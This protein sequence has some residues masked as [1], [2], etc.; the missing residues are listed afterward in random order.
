MS[1]RQV[2]LDIVLRAA[3]AADLPAIRRLHALSFAALASGEHNPAQIAAHTALTEGPE[4]ETD[5]LRSHLML[6]LTS[7]DEIVATAGWIAAPEEPGTARIRKVFVH[8]A[9]ARRGLASRLVQD[10]EQRAQAAGYPRLIVRANRN[11]V[12]LYRK[13]GYAPLSEGVMAAPGG[14]DLPVVFMEK[15][16]AR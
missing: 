10:A 3:E 9:F 15:A 11:A 2:P 6:A 5:V 12:P 13:L 8:P 7:A 14:I 4:Y 1:R 16:A